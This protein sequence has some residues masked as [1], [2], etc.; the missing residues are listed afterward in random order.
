MDHDA[1]FEDFIALTEPR[2]RRAF[3]ARYGADRGQEAAAEAVAYAWE[4]RE[5]VLAMQNPAGYL[6]R[7]GQ[8][9]TRLRSLRPRFPPVPVA[10]VHEVEPGLPAALARLSAR[11]RLAVVLVY[12]YGWTHREVAELT[13]LSTSSIQVHVTRGLSKLRGFMGAHSESLR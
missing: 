3:L 7:V 6:F 10:D 12:G 13:G 1:A 4:H 9:R 8:S 11:Q 2:L 5:K